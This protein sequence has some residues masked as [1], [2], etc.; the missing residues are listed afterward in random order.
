MQCLR[1]VGRCFASHS[2]GCGPSR[3]VSRVT[4]WMLI[5]L[6]TS[7]VSGQ[8]V[9]D[10]QQR[11]AVAHFEQH[12]RPLL[13]QQCVSCHGSEKQEGQLRLDSL[14]AMLAGG[15]SGPAIV[16]GDADSSLLVE[17]IRRES[18]EM[19]PEKP[20][21]K[22]QIGSVIDW[23][24]AGAVWPDQQPLQAANRPITE[25]DRSH[26]SFQPVRLPPLPDVDDLNWCRNAIDRFVRQRQE[27]AGIVP[28]PEANRRTLVR[29]VYLD[30]LGIPPSPS[31]VRQ[32]LDD[33]GPQAYERLVDRLLASPAYSERWGR[34][35]LDV[36]R[37]AESDGFRQDA[38]RPH[39]WRY[40]DYVF[41]TLNED[42][43]FRDFV[44]EQLAGD[45]IAGDKPQ[46]W[47]GTG[48]LR[49]HLYEYNQRDVF[50]Q[51]TDILEEI[52]DVTG[53]VFLGLSL[54]CAKCHDHKFD[55]L[56]RTDYL[57]LE[58]FFGALLLVED[59]P[60]A[61]P[62][63]LAE[64]TQ[65][66]AE[67]EASTADIRA[68][69][70]EI[71]APY[72]KAKRHAAVV[73]FVPELREIADKPAEERTPEE[74]QIAYFTQRQI[75]WEYVGIKLKPEDQERYDALEERLNTFA[76]LKPRE[77]EATVSVTDTGTEAAVIPDPR[78]ENPQGI[79]PAFPQ[80]LG[81][82]R[83]VA[84]PCGDV[85]TGRRR[86]LVRWLID[87]DNP[88]T[89]RVIVNRV[90]QF[91]FGTGLVSTSNDF[92]H[93][94]QP[95]THPDLL[96]WLT[97][98]FQEHNWEWKPLHR[99]IL[100]SSTY[101]QGT[102]HP[103]EPDC[104]AKDPANQWLWHWQVQRLQAEQIR[105]SMLLVSGHLDRALSGASVKAPSQ[106]RS[107]YLRV[108][109]NQ[110]DAFL[111]LFDVPDGV[112]TVAQRDVTTSAPQALALLNDPWTLE[113]SSAFARR[114]A[115]RCGGDV[116]AGVQYAYEL[117]LGRPPSP[118][119]SE[120]ALAFLGIDAECA[121]PSGDEITWDDLAH[122]LLNSNEFLYVD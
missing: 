25:E 31:E 118:E 101:R 50:T 13:S 56:S 44:A 106:R 62:A 68:Q 122:V 1:H 83:A 93:L 92:G 37:Y 63:E 35:W 55:P 4:A 86:E 34:Q 69:I 15:E 113:C 82:Q 116:E 94:G 46:R 96:D 41:S 3:V 78:G 12:V 97:R 114:I 107:C 33:D 53:E 8:T 65:Q 54:R 39:A 90:W 5:L 11:E 47:V 112:N 18:F 109:R 105:D 104:L 49:L 6:V 45:E 73:K 76:Q 9:D 99:L 40:R 36:V 89:S 38:Y 80:V 19:P 119:E 72:R 67:W 24:S 30:L 71:Y 58:S 2:P 17:A 61:T 52:T 117:A 70:D 108:I 121:E 98:Y 21:T 22:T 87:N 16:P 7:G 29:R 85:S 42:R 60:L 26:W 88:L 100:C 57:G 48:Y 120:L 95:P 66:R 110:K 74:Q 28:A 32:F 81:G 102:H 111:G 79:L 43:S 64:Y 115:A 103:D 75:D 59:K 10:A 20:L 23:I 77:F 91:H 27:C 51:R 14:E 84:S